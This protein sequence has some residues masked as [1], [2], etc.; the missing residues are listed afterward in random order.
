MLQGRIASHTDERWEGWG[1]GQ[2]AGLPQIRC[3]LLM[4]GR[5]SMAAAVHFPLCRSGWA[6]NWT[7]HDRCNISCAA[8]D[9]EPAHGGEMHTGGEGCGSAH[10]VD[11]RCKA[12]V[13]A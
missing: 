3:H 10:P 11:A 12:R 13:C 1:Y 4:T 7:K 9:I 2:G 8:I 6:H 5:A